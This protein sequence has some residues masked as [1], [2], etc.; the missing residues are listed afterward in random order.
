MDSDHEYDISDDEE[1]THTPGTVSAA[2]AIPV[3]SA[4]VAILVSP[5]GVTPH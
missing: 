4:P 3:P 1:E 5:P 2:V